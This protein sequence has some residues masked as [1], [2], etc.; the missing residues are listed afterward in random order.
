M[1]FHGSRLVSHGSRLV[2]M[3]FLWFQVVFLWF[4]LG[5]H[6]FSWF[7][8]ENTLK[9]YSG[10]TIQSRPCRPQAG[11]GLVYTKKHHSHH[12]HHHSIHHQ[13]CSSCNQG[14]NNHHRHR[15]FLHKDHYQ[16]HSLVSL[17][18]FAAPK[19]PTALDFVQLAEER[20]QF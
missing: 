14:C 3:I 1:G 10:P 8:V 12:L 4:Q 11:F 13:D 2:L 7:Q 17:F 20:W 16:D 18:D 15:H 6:V 9:L 5:F 19:M